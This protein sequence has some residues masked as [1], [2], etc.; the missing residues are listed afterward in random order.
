[1]LG[2]P[3]FTFWPDVITR[4]TVGDIVQL[5]CGGSGI[6]TPTVTWWRRLGNGTVEEVKSDGRIV[7]YEEGLVFSPVAKGDEGIYYCNIS[8]PLQTRITADAMLRV[9]SKLATILL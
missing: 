1:M 7:I 9:F 4:S 2:R 8:S 6:P 5:W 3:F